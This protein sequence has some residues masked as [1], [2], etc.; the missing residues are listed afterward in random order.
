MGYKLQV[1]SNTSM[2]SQ[3]SYSVIV[4]ATTNNTLCLSN[5]WDVS[6][7]GFKFKFVDGTAV[8]MTNC[9]DAVT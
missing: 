3:D 6:D 7:E 2:S 4:A 5:N 8:D 9:L 1:D